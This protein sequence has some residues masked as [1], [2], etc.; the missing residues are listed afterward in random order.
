MQATI[1]RVSI[2]SQQLAAPT[3]K[4]ATTGWALQGYVVDTQN[5]PMAKFTVFLVDANHEFLKC[6]GFAYTD[7][8]GYFVIKYA[9]D[10]TQAAQG[11]LTGQMIQTGQAAQT[12]QFFVAVVNADAHLP[13]LDCISTHAGQSDVSKHLGPGGRTDPG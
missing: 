3:V 9:G 5:N 7:D 10:S 8:K 1:A 13:R 6:Y 12:A 11:A 2:V 4:V